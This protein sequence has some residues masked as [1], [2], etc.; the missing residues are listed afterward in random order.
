VA[1]YV[2]DRR[3]LKPFFTRI[4]ALARR[5]IPGHAAAGHADYI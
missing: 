4:A 5:F 1:F 2:S 3:G